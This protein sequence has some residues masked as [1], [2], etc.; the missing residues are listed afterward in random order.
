MVKKENRSYVGNSLLQTASSKRLGAGRFALLALKGNPKPPV[1]KVKIPLPQTTNKALLHVVDDG[2]KISDMT[3]SVGESSLLSRPALVKEVLQP[4]ADNNN[5]D[6][7]MDVESSVMDMSMNSGIRSTDFSPTRAFVPNLRSAN[8]VTAAPTNPFRNIGTSVKTPIQPSVHVKAYQ[9]HPSQK[10]VSASLSHPKGALQKK[11]M[12]INKGITFSA[13]SPMT[14]NRFEVQLS[15]ERN[16]PESKEYLQE[17]AK[18]QKKLERKM[19]L[20][21]RRLAKR[22]VKEELKR[23]FQ[24]EQGEGFEAQLDDF[25]VNDAVTNKAGF[26]K[27][28]VKQIL[29]KI[30]PKSPQKGRHSTMQQQQ[31]QIANA[32]TLD[33]ESATAMARQALMV[34]KQKTGLGAGTMDHPIAV[35]SPQNATMLDG[36]ATG[37]AAVLS[38]GRQMPDGQF[39]SFPVTEILMDTKQDSISDLDASFRRAPVMEILMGSRGPQTR[40][41]ESVST[42]GTPRVFEKLDSLL[43]DPHPDPPEIAAVESHPPPPMVLS[44]DANPLIDQLE[45]GEKSSG[46]R[47]TGTEAVEKAALCNPMHVCFMDSQKS[48]SEKA[49]PNVRDHH[50][51]HIH[52][53]DQ[54]NNENKLKA[55]VTEIGDDGVEARLDIDVS[56]SDFL[57]GE[58]PMFDAVE[59]KSPQ[60]DASH[61][62][63]T[64]KTPVSAFSAALDQAIQ[65]ANAE[66]K[67]ADRGAFPDVQLQTA[68]SPIEEGEEAA[69]PRSAA[70]PGTEGTNDQEKEKYDVI[71]LTKLEFDMDSKRGERSDKMES[72]LTFA[73]GVLK[74]VPVQDSKN[75]DFENLMEIAAA[76]LDT[77]DDRYAVENDDDKYAMGNVVDVEDVENHSSGNPSQVVMGRIVEISPREDAPIVKG[78]D[79]LSTT[80]K[81]SN[82]ATPKT[83]GGIQKSFFDIDVT[84]SS[85]STGD[86]EIYENEGEIVICS[87]DP[88]KLPTSPQHTHNTE[89]NQSPRK[90]AMDDIEP[91]QTFSGHFSEGLFDLLPSEEG[92]AKKQ[93]FLSQTSL[94][95]SERNEHRKAQQEP[96]PDAKEKTS[97]GVNPECKSEQK[98]NAIVPQEDGDALDGVFQYSDMLLCGFMGRK[99]EDQKSPKGLPLANTGVSKEL[100]EAQSKEHREEVNQRDLASPKKQQYSTQK[101]GSTRANV[102]DLIEAEDGNHLLDHDD[103]YWDTLSTIASTTKDKSSDSDKYLYEAAIPGPIPIEI[104]T[105]ASKDVEVRDRG[106]SKHLMNEKV[107]SSKATKYQAQK[108]SRTGSVLSGD[109]QIQSPPSHNSKNDEAETASKGSKVAEL[110]AVFESSKSSGSEGETHGEYT[111][112]ST[113][114]SALLLAV[115][116]SDSG[117]NATPINLSNVEDSQVDRH[118]TAPTPA[119]TRSV[120]S[121]G[122][123]KSKSSEKP[124]PEMLMD[125]S[126]KSKQSK[127]NRSV[128]WGYEEIYE[129]PE[130]VT[131]RFQPGLEDLNE[132]DESGSLGLGSGEFP[133]Q[134]PGDRAILSAIAAAAAGSA[135][136]KSFD[137]QD[138]GNGSM[139]LTEAEQQNLLARTLELSRGLFGSLGTQDLKGTDEEVVK[140]IFSFGMPWSGQPHEKEVQVGKT[141][142]DHASGTGA[143]QTSPIDV[144]NL[145]SQ[146]DDLAE[147]RLER[148]QGLQDHTFPQSNQENINAVGN[149]VSSSVSNQSPVRSKLDLLREQRTRA[150]ERF[151]LAK[152]LSSSTGPGSGSRALQTSTPRGRDRD[153]LKNYLTTPRNSNDEHL[154]ATALSKDAPDTTTSRR[155]QRPHSTGRMNMNRYPDEISITSSSSSAPSQKARELRRQ[156]DEALKASQSIRMSQEKL[157]DELRSFKSKYYRKNDEIEDYALRAMGGGF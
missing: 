25:E 76:K 91:T 79:V 112:N 24:R 52:N 72:R 90:T 32:G 66:S 17:Q 71:D 19:E 65:N 13:P 70:S 80:K 96:I 26:K 27:S 16:A 14:L 123:Q 67:A 88:N 49:L 138:K 18:K 93:Q 118:V 22:A 125:R 149:N 109:D 114:G 20:E 150:L 87:D 4:A 59:V 41:D 124:C 126:R 153:R 35:A 28:F 141:E 106:I 129:A 152:P 36:A 136:T 98:A 6:D 5:D 74:T 131:G 122:S 121:I 77:T 51:M 104:T 133:N 43:R 85:S 157:G 142:T 137:K 143:S 89:Q 113:E 58:K 64:N 83:R 38:T 63:E 75:N 110:I 23:E 8:L 12:A 100:T 34:S 11:S 97:K 116:R 37:V 55:K 86:F 9:H 31:Q 57:L 68:L 82:E 107:T 134:D 135:L 47:S 3:L 78:V 54:E 60:T 84:G 92:S 40:D 39:A 146:Y 101:A 95:A 156:L 48:S 81:G 117:G 127:T 94:D 30:R 1:K 108:L 155:N 151:H 115:T 103:A 128:S 139:P 42:L 99:Q 144:E 2:S 45:S 132:Y 120:A 15:R 145:F 10:T 50:N 147:N 61:A 46:E 44:Q 7:D 53:E 130:Q 105:T 119:T 33:K 73:P 154:R 62:G 29:G 69:S 140:S 148:N 102:I 56:Q 111:V 21:H